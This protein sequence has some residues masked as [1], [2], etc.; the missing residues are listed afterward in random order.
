MPSIVGNN[1]LISV[2]IPFYN[3]EDYL[4]YAIQSVICQSYENWELILIDDGSTDSSL[5]IANL[6]AKKDSRIRVISD[7]ENKKLPFRLNQLIG[8]SRGEYIARMDAD[9]IMHPDR[10]LTQLM[11]LENNQSIDIVSSGL[12]SIDANNNVCGFRSTSQIVTNLSIDKGFPIIHPTVMA[13][14][15]W[16]LRNLYNENYARAQDFELWCRSY[17]NNDLKIAILPDLL[18]FYREFGNI[19][20]TK[21]VKSYNNGYKIR[22]SFGIKVGINYFLKMKIKCVVIN[23]LSMVNLEQYL[24]KRRNKSFLSLSEKER[25]QS[26]VNSI[27]N[28]L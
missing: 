14:K 11:Y 25:Y 19:D 18:L 7:G 28:S 24:A 9:D 26:I 6:Y 23:L 4:A 3:N 5:D 2:G 21:L 17:I 22:Q 16:Y 27:V 13:R 10:L 20:L 12:I 1:P 8:E 15:H